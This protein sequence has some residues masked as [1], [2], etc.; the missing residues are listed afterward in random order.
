MGPTNVGLWHQ[1]GITDSVSHFKSPCNASERIFV[2]SDAPYL[3]KLCRNHLLDKSYVFP[4]GTAVLRSDLEE[5]LSSDNGVYKIHPKLK[6]Y[7]FTCQGSERQRV[8][9]AAQLLS[10]HT[11]AALQF[12]FPEKVEQALFVKLVNDWFDV[13]NLR[14][15]NDGTRLKSGYGVHMS[16]QETV[17][18]KTIELISKT[19]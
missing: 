15:K 1:L 11:A 17:V 5:I 12:L 8:C 6:S 3:L 13:A 4:T 2:F 7:L 10:N 18:N 19:F 14:S 16:E 9:W